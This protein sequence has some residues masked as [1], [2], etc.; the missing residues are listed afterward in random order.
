MTLGETVTSIA[1][2]DR[3]PAGTVVVFEHPAYRMPIAAVRVARADGPLVWEVTGRDGV[4]TTREIRRS[5]GW[6]VE[7]RIVSVPDPDPR[8]RR[9]PGFTF[10]TTPA[11][12]GSDTTAEEVPS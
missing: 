4:T 8:W 1:A 7:F 9:K 12:A 5:V 10:E 2:A 3:L 11:S 6:R